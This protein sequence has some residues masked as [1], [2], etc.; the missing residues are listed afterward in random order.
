MAEEGAGEQT[1]V[2]KLLATSVWKLL[3]GKH[4]M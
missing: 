1:D 3:V 4:C 2:V